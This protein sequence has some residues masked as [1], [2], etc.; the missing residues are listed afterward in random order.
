MMITEHDTM[1]TAPLLAL[2][3]SRIKAVKATYLVK[4]V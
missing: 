1:A 4:Y 3:M 2:D